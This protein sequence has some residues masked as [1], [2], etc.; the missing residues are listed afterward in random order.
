MTST[1]NRSPTPPLNASKLQRSSFE[2]PHARRNKR[3]GDDRLL[4]SSYLS[5]ICDDVPTDGEEEESVHG[6][7]ATNALKQ[8]EDDEWFQEEPQED[9]QN[10][11]TFEPLIDVS[12][13]SKKSKISRVLSM[14]RLSDAPSFES[15]KHDQPVTSA[16]RVQLMA[17]IK[18]SVSAP[19]LQTLS[20]QPRKFSVSQFA[21][22]NPDTHLR[23]ILR[24][25]GVC[26]V[27][28]SALDLKGFFHETTEENISSYGTD[29]ITAVCQEDIAT[30]RNMHHGGRMLLC[31][32]RFGESIVHM[33]C[34]RG[35]EK[36]VRFLL[37]EADVDYR[38]RD[39]YGRTPL[40]DACWTR[41]PEIELV[42]MLITRCPDLLLITDKRGFTPLSYV[43]KDHWG[44]W[45]EF[46]ESNRHLL[47]PTELR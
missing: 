47:I 21:T 36:V 41:E 2:S 42:K 1:P 14:P 28:H 23:N 40:H 33:A 3:K 10:H 11:V 12:H 46:L 22:T 8:L 20:S 35:A 25:L 13:T 37:D 29:V 18:K 27:T 17:H 5:F 31:C 24:E 32:N 34:R 44:L 6:K 16:A 30:L 15:S 43:R 9:F 19:V 4:I 38:L 26:P 39:D 7:H 45:C